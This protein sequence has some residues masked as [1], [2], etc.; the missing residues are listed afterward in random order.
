MGRK[1]QL[2]LFSLAYQRTRRFIAIVSLRG[3]SGW[4]ESPKWFHDS[5][6]LWWIAAMMGVECRGRCYPKHITKPVGVT[7][8]QEGQVC[9][10]RQL[11]KCRPARI[12]NRSWSRKR[13]GMQGRGKEQWL[14]RIIGWA[15]HMR[16]VDGNS[17]SDVQQ[18]LDLLWVQVTTS[19][20]C[21]KVSRYSLFR[22]GA[23]NTAGKEPIEALINL[24]R[25]TDIVLLNKSNLLEK[26][27]RKLALPNDS[28]V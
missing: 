5:G 12:A 9:R 18:S 16:S 24:W 7:H 11:P 6:G 20:E 22:E 17:Y 21:K 14:A 15:P 13:V 23:A 26:C 1:S 10:G 2:Y 27:L 3:A 8:C 19:A 4:V 28:W 25:L